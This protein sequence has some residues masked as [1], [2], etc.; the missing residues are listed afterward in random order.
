MTEVRGGVWRAG[1]GAGARSQRCPLQRR[2]RRASPSPP[3]PLAQFWVSNKRK[4]C[5]Y[6]KCWL[7]DTTAAWAVHERGTGHKANVAKSE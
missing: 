4:W 2:R 1:R 7:A 3:L 6:C 5:E